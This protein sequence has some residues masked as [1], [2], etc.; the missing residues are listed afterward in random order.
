MHVLESLKMDEDSLLADLRGIADTVLYSFF[1]AEKDKDRKLELDKVN[2]LAQ[3]WFSSGVALEDFTGFKEQLLWIRKRVHPFSWHIEFPE[4]FSRENPGFDS[5]VGNPPFLGGIKISQY[6]GDTYR[7]WLQR[8]IRESTSRMDLVGYFFR[9]VNGLLRKDGTFGLIATNSI[10]QGDSRAACTR[11]LANEG[12][13]YSVNKRVSW[14]GDAAVV[15]S[16]VCYQKGMFDGERTLDGKSVGNINAYFFNHINNAEPFILSNNLN[17]SFR[18]VCLYGEGF[19]FDD[20]NKTGTSNSL[21]EME[22]LISKNSRNQDVI[23]P[24]IGGQE[25][26]EEA[27]QLPKRYVINFGTRS[28]AE[29]SEWPD[30]LSLLENKVKPERETKTKDVA[31]WPWWHYWRPREELFK[32]IKNLD[33]ILVIPRVSNSFAFTFLSNQ[34]VINDKVIVLPTN[35]FAVFALLQSRVHETWVRYFSSTLKDD[36]QY[37]PTLCLE[38][39]PF[40]INIEDDETLSMVGEKYFIWR[41]EV[42]SSGNHGL[43]KF[44][45][46]FHDPSDVSSEIVRAREL[47]SDLDRAVFSSYGWSDLSVSS[48]YQ[49]DF[50]EVDDDHSSAKKKR[51]PWKLRLPEFLRDEVLSRLLDINL[52]SNLSILAR[53]NE[54]DEE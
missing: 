34:F 29:A 49:L 7:D 50:E 17:S 48:E 25:I 22:H 42:M 47:H 4:V 23:F 26:N 11:P 32:A 3:N 20:S 1:V 38:T 18:G 8:D 53:D 52:R 6:F 19:L 45:N 27:V 13:F 2:L 28:F 41:N 54:G 10:S 5:I 14:P 9:R 39:F 44:Y 31:S 24:Y 16:I 40:P 12:S 37:T 36:L 15:V 51:K 33:K 30:I 35:S 43:T 21:A 46:R